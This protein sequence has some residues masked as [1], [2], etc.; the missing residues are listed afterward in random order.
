LLL[1]PLLGGLWWLLKNSRSQPAVKA[2]ANA[3]VAPITP[4]GTA[5]PQAAAAIPD[6]QS[7]NI[8]LYEERL[9]ADKTRQKVADV[10]VSKRVETQQTQVSV[11]IEKERV[12]IEHTLP[13]DANLHAGDEKP[14]EALGKVARIETYE[15]MPDIHKETFVWEEVSVSKEIEHDTVEAEATLRKEQ[16]DL[17]IDG[18]PVIDPASER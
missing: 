15:E 9:V 6:Q 2:V 18:T 7:P 16:L 14:F 10:A 17:N 8:K 13:S 4:T 5:T 12:V 1:I 11:P 3:K